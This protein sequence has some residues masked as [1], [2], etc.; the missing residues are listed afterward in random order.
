MENLSVSKIHKLIK[1]DKPLSQ[2]INE[3]KQLFEAKKRDGRSSKILQ[4]MSFDTFL[5]R[6]YQKNLGI[7]GHENADAKKTPFLDTLKQTAE[8]L[9]SQPSDSIVTPMPNTMSPVKKTILGMHPIVFYSA[10]GAVLLVT[11]LLIYKMV[12]KRV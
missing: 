3:E 10:T 9:K 1:T 5:N 2:F 12:K 6:R 11:G 4:G 7:I 8:K